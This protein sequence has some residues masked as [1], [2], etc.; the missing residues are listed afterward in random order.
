MRARVMKFVGCVIFLITLPV[1]GFS[2]QSYSSRLMY[3]T[4][5]TAQL[6]LKWRLLNPVIP[7]N[8]MRKQVY[9]KLGKGNRDGRA[10]WEKFSSD[11]GT[12]R[13]CIIPTE[14]GVERVTIVTLFP[15]DKLTWR[16]L[17]KSQD[18]L[19]TV[20]QI[21]SS[22]DEKKTLQIRIGNLDSKY[23]MQITVICIQE[24]VEQITWTLVG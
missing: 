16:D 2:P 3:D 19:H 22:E 13:A 10:G 21:R 4:P 23:A 14:D 12:I 17:L 24:K 8:F 20:E 18:A 7:L 5:A 11:Y 1:L 9:A 6:H 15:K